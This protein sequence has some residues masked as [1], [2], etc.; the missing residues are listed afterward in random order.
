MGGYD[1][2]QGVLNIR[3]TPDKANLEDMMPAR[4]WE[5]VKDISMS[6]Y[7]LLDVL[8]DIENK[9]EQQLTAQ[10]SS[11]RLENIKKNLLGMAYVCIVAIYNIEIVP[12]TACRRLVSSVTNFAKIWDRSFPNIV[13]SPF[14]KMLQ[15][16]LQDDKFKCEVIRP[17]F[18]FHSPKAT[19]DKWEWQHER[20]HR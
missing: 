20:G 6:V 13:S 7:E 9:L 14:P 16:V 2:G 17:T 19:L 4:D 1:N 8:E 10:P 18:S 3:I 12:P 11:A 15:K 5:K